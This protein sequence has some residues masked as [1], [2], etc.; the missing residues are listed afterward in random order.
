MNNTRDKS[1]LPATVSISQP[2]DFPLG[3]VESR[4]AMRAMIEHKGENKKL[5]RVTLERIGGG[6]DA[7][8]SIKRIDGPDCVVVLV[9]VG[10]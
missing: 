1:G 10:G 3:S 6:T 7:P 5:V 2:G 4:A 9:R 8:T